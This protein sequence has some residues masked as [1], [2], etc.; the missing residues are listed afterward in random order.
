MKNK[1]ILSISFLVV[2]ALV[3]TCIYFYLPKEKEKEKVE[4]PTPD[5]FIEIGTVSLAE[6]G[7][8]KDITELF[9]YDIKMEIKEEKDNSADKTQIITLKDGTN[10]V[11]NDYLAD[12]QHKIRIEDNKLII[13]S[14]IANYEIKKIYNEKYTKMNV[15]E[16]A[17]PFINE[18]GT[19]KNEY[20]TLYDDY[21]TTNGEQTDL[22]VSSLEEG[23]LNTYKKITEFTERN[24]LSR[25]VLLMP[26]GQV[27]TVAEK[28]FDVKL[29]EY[30]EM[31]N[32][33]AL[34]DYRVSDTLMLQKDEDN[35]VSC[36]YYYLMGNAGSIYAVHVNAITT[37][38]DDYAPLDAL[39]FVS[40]S[41]FE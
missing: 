41:W 16:D 17:D 28:V 5:N 10:I 23:G 2:I 21:V 37:P 40:L 35:G 30:G 32:H 18:Y 15:E 24:E 36:D 38:G 34:Y 31:L 22:V 27:K 25:D 4:L 1:I 19:I 12:Y 26:I 33:L 8:E 39:G 11:L 6:R 13:K 14:D 7:E 20:E 3:I 29:D 9:K